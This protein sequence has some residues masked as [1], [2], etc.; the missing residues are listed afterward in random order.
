MSFLNIHKICYKLLPLSIKKKNFFL[1]KPVD[2]ISVFILISEDI[3]FYPTINQ[4]RQN[5]RTI[6]L[7]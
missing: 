7:S 4:V 5:Y 1:L 3:Y 6:F 2:F